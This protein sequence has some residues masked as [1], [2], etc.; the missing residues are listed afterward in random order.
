M[1]RNHNK[2]E[3]LVVA[4]HV[5][6]LA[7]EDSLVIEDLAP[8]VQY[9]IVVEAIVS[10]KTSLDPEKWD[11]GIEKY[12]RTAHVMSSPL[13]ARTRAPIEPPQVLLTS[14]TETTAN[15]YWE[16]P[17]L[18]SLV[19]KDDDGN[20]EYLRRYLEGYKLE[21]NGKLQCYLGPSA[22]SCTLTK[23]RPGKL[24]EVTL[25]AMTC[26]EEVKK[27]RKMRVSHID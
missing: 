22:Q 23:C 20:P 7:T 24:Y 11:S 26:T 14:Y 27:M 3:D 5:N 25:V 17:Q 19:G 12:R 4:S 16:K 13:L 2:D 18:M 10:I 1:K 15:L 8:G 6:L 9:R 21:V